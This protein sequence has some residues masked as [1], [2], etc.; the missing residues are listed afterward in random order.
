[1]EP[2]DLAVLAA[3][4]VEEMLPQAQQKNLEL[5][6]LPAPELPPLQSD[7][8]LVRLILT[9]LLDNALK[10]TEQGGVEVSIGLEE[11]AHRLA[12]RDTGPGIATEQQAL[13]FEPFEQLEP[14]RQKHTPGVGLGLALVREMAGALG[15]RIELTSQPGAGSTFSVV[16]PPA[17]VK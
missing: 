2:I 16:L 4:T 9:N 5:G 6:L 13:I 15:G 8:R 10:Y 1:V 11:G 3:E 17:S 7:P 12:V 14:I